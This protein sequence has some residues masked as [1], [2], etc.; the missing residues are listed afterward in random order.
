MS[1]DSFASLV[2]VTRSARCLTAVATG[3]YRLWMGNFWLKR[4]LASSRRLAVA[5]CSSLVRIWKQP[6]ALPK[7]PSLRCATVPGV[8]LP[9]PGGIVRSG[10]K[11][12]SRYKFLF[13][14]TNDAYCPTLRG[15][16]PETTRARR[17]RLRHG[18]RYRWPGPA[19][20]RG[21][22]AS[23]DRELPPKMAPNRFRP[24]TMAAR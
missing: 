12:S 20:D 4:S 6:C 3:A 13:A 10:S 7:R 5:I 8:I 17:C 2:T 19:S 21:K 23:R 11:T 15:F 18:N 9:F 1:A 22:H 16:A 14:S 24:A